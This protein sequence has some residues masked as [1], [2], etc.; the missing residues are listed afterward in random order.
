MLPQTVDV[1]EAQTRLF[2]LLGAVTAGTEFTLTEGNKPVA[3]LVPVTPPIVS[4]VAGL[5]VGAIWA[6]DDFD[7]P[8]PDAFWSGD[9]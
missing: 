9:T 7:E 3:R 8:L 1:Y 4:R 5:H 6:R 2:E